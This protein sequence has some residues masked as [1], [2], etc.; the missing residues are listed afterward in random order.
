[1]REIYI[2]RRYRS[3]LGPWNN[4]ELEPMSPPAGLARG[5]LCALPLALLLWVLLGAVL[6]F[7]LAVLSASIALSLAFPARTARN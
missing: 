2:P 4:S 1:M 7:V 3:D 6:G 5:I